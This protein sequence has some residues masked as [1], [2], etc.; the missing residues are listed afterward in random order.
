MAS[1]LPEQPVGALAKSPEPAQ[2]PNSSTSLLK[3]K[4]VSLRPLNITGDIEALYNSLCGPE[5]DRLWTYMPGGPFPSLATF[6][7]YLDK[8]SADTFAFT[9]FTH[10]PTSPSSSSEAGIPENSK[11]VG[12]TTLMSIVPAHHRIE[13]G[14]VIYG[15]ALKRST[16]ATECVFLLLEHAFGLG[17]ERVEWKCD[18]LNAPSRS[19]AGRLGF[20]AEGVFLRHMIIKGRRRDT[21]WFS[22][23]AEEWENWGRQAIH[24]W[25]SE[26]NFNAEGQQKRRLEGIR[27]G[28]M[29]KVKKE[30][31]I[32]KEQIQPAR[33]DTHEA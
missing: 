6:E 2:T 30:D 11:V 16:A 22:I 23:M 17:Y 19:A 32:V 33:D 27:D 21:A 7:Q 1:Q 13:I 31:D 9:I 3:G 20:R 10:P 8:L 4:H 18:S 5:N 25:L 26:E 28:L 12:I 24:I 29:L 14:H 15:E